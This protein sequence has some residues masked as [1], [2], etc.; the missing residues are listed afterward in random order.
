MV[1]RVQK[2]WSSLKQV[3]VSTFV[4]ET[5][6]LFFD[7]DTGIIRRSDGVTLGGIPIFV[8][9][10]SA[11]AL[12][13][14]T[15]PAAPTNGLLWYNPDTN[16]LSVYDSGVWESVVGGGST[17]G[18]LSDVDTV[19]TQDGDVLV[20]NSTS[21][22]FENTPL[23]LTGGALNQV[24]VKQSGSDYDYQWEDMIIQIPDQ[25]YTKLLD[26]VS[27]TVL[28]LGEAIPESL[29]ANAVWRIQKIL[30]DASGN[31]D[32]VRFA[33]TGEFDQIWNNRLALTYI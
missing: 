20:Y 5:G 27:S 21:S 29:E 14:N 26:Q 12:F 13:Q 19:N 4:G 1:N 3:D 30:F 2:L 31:V 23:N 24:L 9:G 33:S 6:E 28:Y 32:E 18:D 8:S 22:T 17:L 11:S 10:S 7:S 25:A 15:A 16:T